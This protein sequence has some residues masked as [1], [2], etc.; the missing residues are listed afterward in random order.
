MSIL[1]LMETGGRAIAM[2]SYRSN[3]DAV[4]GDVCY[5]DGTSSG[6]TVGRIGP[7]EALQFQKGTAKILGESSAIT[8]YSKH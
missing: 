6:C 4:H 2:V 8:T 3:V 5:T 7:S 1:G